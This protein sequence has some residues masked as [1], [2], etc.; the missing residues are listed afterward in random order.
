MEGQYFSTLNDFGLNMK[1]SDIFFFFFFFF[2]FMDDGT[3]N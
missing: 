2:F 3:K 1:A